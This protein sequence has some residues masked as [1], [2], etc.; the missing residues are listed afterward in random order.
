VE[1][2]IHASRI[3][4]NSV[5][6]LLTRLKFLLAYE[7]VHKSGQNRIDG[8]RSQEDALMTT[9]TPAEPRSASDPID[10]EHPG[11]A[12][13]HPTMTTT[14]RVSRRSVVRTASKLVYAAPLV[15]ATLKLGADDASAQAVSGIRP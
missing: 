5:S 7:K 9:G 4:H 1:H 11:E 8:R 2:S 6:V 3:R 12:A 13:N 15:V 10:L 14:T